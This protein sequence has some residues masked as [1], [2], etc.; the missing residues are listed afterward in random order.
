MIERLVIPACLLLFAVPVQPASA[1]D[2]TGPCFD[3]SGS[4]EFD[5]DLFRSSDPEA[6]LFHDVY[7]TLDT[8]LALRARAIGAP[9][10]PLPYSWQWAP[11]AAS[12]ALSCGAEP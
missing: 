10:L 5:G 6:G 7:P 2:C 12:S 3:V 11:T 9:P 4:Y 8:T 1:G